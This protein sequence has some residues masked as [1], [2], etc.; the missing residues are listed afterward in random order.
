MP[1]QHLQVQVPVR[2][3]TILEQTVTR[4][5][6]DTAVSMKMEMVMTTI[7]NLHLVIVPWRTIVQ[8]G[9]MKI[10]TA[11]VVTPIMMM[12]IQKLRHWKTIATNIQMMFRPVPMHTIPTRVLKISHCW[13]MKSLMQ[14]VPSRNLRSLRDTLLPPWLWCFPS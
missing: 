7:Q 13:R 10:A 2:T 9:W 14:W 8:N 1:V 12:V 11:L 6:V 5:S 4:L 3:C